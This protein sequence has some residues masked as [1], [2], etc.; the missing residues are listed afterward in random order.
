VPPVPSP[1]RHFALLLGILISL[2]ALVLALAAAF[3]PLLAPG[4]RPAWMLF[5]F[6]LVVLTTGVLVAF[7]GRGRFADGP[8][9][10]LGTLAGTL[11]L[12]SAFGWISTGKQLAGTSLTPL[13]GLRLAAGLLLAAAGTY[14]VLSRNPKSWRA[15]A[16][17]ALCG[18]PAAVLAAA[19]LTSGGRRALM[20]FLSGGGMFQTALAILILIVVG[21]L[22]C[23]SVH[24]LIK[25]FEMGRVESPP[26]A[27]PAQAKA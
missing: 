25:A 27:E 17:G 4:E 6:E 16:I 24:M 5:G 15:F 14:C 18:T 26:V 22:L 11:V 19:F 21:G 20:T 10:A 1:I 13:L 12:A 8:G 3:L 9:L 2:S 7:F 23:A